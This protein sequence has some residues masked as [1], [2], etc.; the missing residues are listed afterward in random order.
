[1]GTAK[2]TKSMNT[3]GQD[4]ALLATKPSD[5]DSQVLANNCAVQVGFLGN[6]PLDRSETF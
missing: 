2:P 1:V 3:R 4:N 5:S 6:G